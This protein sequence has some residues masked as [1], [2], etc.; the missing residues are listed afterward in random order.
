V[1]TRD[2]ASLD[3]LHA[4][5]PQVLLLLGALIFRLTHAVDKLVLLRFSRAPPLYPARL[6]LY[7]LTLFKYA[8]ALHLLLG[9]WVFS[10]SREDGGLLFP[11][12]PISDAVPPRPDPT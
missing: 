2:R 4:S 5:W 9:C 7:V 12:P 10:A 11:R 3:A 8:A 1:P 6:A